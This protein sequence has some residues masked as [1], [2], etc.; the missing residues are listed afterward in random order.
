M[1]GRL[2]PHRESNPRPSGLYERESVNRSQMDIKRKTRDIRTCKNIYFPTYPPPI[3]IH[4]PHRF[5]SALKPAAQ[6]SFDQCLS[7]FRTSTATRLPPRCFLADQIDG[8][9]QGPSPG[10]KVDVQEVPTVVL[11]FS[12]GLLGLYG[13]WHCLD[14]AVLL[15]PVSLDVFY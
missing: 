12:P 11:Q 10:C 1:A 3:L 4:L 6:K 15:L 13:V 2:Q 7:Y 9:H 8:S 14:E 5:T